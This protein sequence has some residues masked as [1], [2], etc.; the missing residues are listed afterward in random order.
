M[1]SF[2]KFAVITRAAYHGHFEIAELLLNSKVFVLLSWF[3]KRHYQWYS[4]S[5]SW[6]IGRAETFLLCAR[7]QYA[8]RMF[9]KWFDLVTLA[10]SNGKMEVKSFVCA[11]KL[12][13]C[14]K[15]NMIGRISCLMHFSVCQAATH[16]WPSH[17]VLWS[18]RPVTPS[19]PPRLSGVDGRAGGRAI[20]AAG[21]RGSQCKSSG[22]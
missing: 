22:F 14:S 2:I 18:W 20:A 5:Y 8:H 15:T 9:L 16:S 4:W 7:Y 13:F 3:W 19:I 17:H 10:L 6:L 11:T 21:R 12:V 1:P